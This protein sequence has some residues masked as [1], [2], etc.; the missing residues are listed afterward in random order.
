MNF[1]QKFESGLG[2]DQ[3]LEK[4]GSESDRQKWAGVFDAVELT[5]L[6][7]ELIKSFVREMNVLV[8]AGAWCGDCVSQC[9]I[10]K[11]I[12]AA[13]PKIQFRYVDRDADAELAQELKI[14]GGS[15]VPQTVIMNEDFLVVSRDGDRTLSRY[16]K[17][18]E[19]Q[20]GNACPTGLVMDSDPTLALVI[21]DWIDI[22][23]R[24]HLI[25]RLSP[26]MRKKHGD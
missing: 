23:E 12:T 15:R 4:Y 7:T 26:G 10:F 17:M 21:Q 19:D 13:N 8:M 3:F 11:R 1:Q 24:A 18:A 6:Q 25:L 14:C 22:L 16:R 2:Y 9:P 5:A 20:F